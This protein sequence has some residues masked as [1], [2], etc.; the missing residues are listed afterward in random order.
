[1]LKKLVFYN[2]PKL[3]SITNVLNGGAMSKL[4]YVEIR[5]CSLLKRLPIGIE[6]LCNL[7]EICGEEDWWSDIIW[8]D[9]ATRVK[10]QPLFRDRLFRDR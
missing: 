1:M 10:L 5:R 2:L 4:Q 7:K 6:K 9:E 8:E 3:E